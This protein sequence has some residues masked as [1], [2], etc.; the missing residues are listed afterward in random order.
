M[1]VR[2]QPAAQT[3]NSETVMLVDEQQ[4]KAKSKFELVLQRRLE[5]DAAEAKERREA[6]SKSRGY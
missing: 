4:Y 2:E 3:T 5:I 1:Q 6:G